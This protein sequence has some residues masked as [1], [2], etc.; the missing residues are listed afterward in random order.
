MIYFTVIA[1][2]A[3]TLSRA[4]GDSTRQNI[5]LNVCNTK[6][7][8]SSSHWACTIMMILESSLEL[9]LEVS[10]KIQENDSL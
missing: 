5:L 1:Q 4:F 8:V 2:A 10:K 6:I 7:K 3:P 9:S